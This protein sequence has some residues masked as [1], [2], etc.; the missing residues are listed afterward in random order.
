MVSARLG[1]QDG[2][3][4]GERRGTQLSLERILPLPPPHDWGP[5]GG[6]GGRSA[7]PSRG[8]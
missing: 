5:A 2:V 3:K 6:G 7:T 4:S 1:P 8:R